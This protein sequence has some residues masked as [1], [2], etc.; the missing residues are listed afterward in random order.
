MH[1]LPGTRKQYFFVPVRIGITVRVGTISELLQL[2][3]S[4]NAIH[5]RIFAQVHFFV[6][7][8]IVHKAGMVIRT[9]YFGH[10]G[11]GTK[12]YFEVI[13]YLCFTAFTTFSGDQDYAIGSSCTIRSYCRSILQYSHTFYFA[14]VEL[15]HATS[16]DAVHYDQGRRGSR[17]TGSADDDGR[18]VI[19]GLATG[20]LNQ[21]A[22]D[23]SAE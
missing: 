11:R 18:I 9:G 8:C 17:R 16:D 3:F 23:A 19:S 20:L 2:F 7:P 22:A 12:S 1:L 6:A 10:T 13:V 14:G 4:I 21:Y 5:T 15:R